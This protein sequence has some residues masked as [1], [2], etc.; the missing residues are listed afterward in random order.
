MLSELKSALNTIWR[1][2]ER[3][4]V[5]EIVKKKVVFL[6]ILLGIG[7]GW[8]RA[9]DLIRHIADFVLSPQSP[10][11]FLQRCT[12]FCRMLR[13]SGVMYGSASP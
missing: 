13:W 5:K 10:L 2:R 8:L 12:G 3:S 9:P 11:C 6:G 1:T 7:G 4:D